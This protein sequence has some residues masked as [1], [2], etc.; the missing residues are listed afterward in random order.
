MPMAVQLTV[1]AGFPVF[2]RSE[3][4]GWGVSSPLIVN[5]CQNDINS[6]V[7]LTS[8]R[9]K[10]P[11]GAAAKTKWT[12]NKILPDIIIDCDFPMAFY[13]FSV[14]CVQVRN[15][16]NPFFISAVCLFDPYP[17]IQQ[18]CPFKQPVCS[19]VGLRGTFCGF[20]WVYFLLLLGWF[21]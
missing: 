18:S 17:P 10:G 12:C 14:S 19:S 15:S 13:I 11:L 4:K 3:V 9:G 2:S 8:Q 16:K 6:T 21:F 20:I 5:G 7:F 1:P